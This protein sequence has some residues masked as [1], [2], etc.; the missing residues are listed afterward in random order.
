MPDNLSLGIQKSRP[1]S[2]DKILIK[3][4]R[5]FGPSDQKYSAVDKEIV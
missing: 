4:T 5:F 2:S 3:P 1:S